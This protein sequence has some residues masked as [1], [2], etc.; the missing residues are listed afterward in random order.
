MARGWESKSIES[1]IE[2]SERD[3]RRAAPPRPTPEQAARERERASL[4]LSRK[5]VLADIAAARHP[6]HRET[7]EAALKFLDEKIAKLT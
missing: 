7:L 6:R 2:S 4:E 1:Q 5:R 3:R